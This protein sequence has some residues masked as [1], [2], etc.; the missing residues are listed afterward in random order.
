MAQ[1][2]DKP[3]SRRERQIMDILYETRECSAHDIRAR[4]VDAPS[5]STVR[6]LLAKM[7]EKGY[8]GNR[9]DG[10]RYIYFPLQELGA[11]R[12]N[13]LQRLVKIFFNGSRISAVTALLGMRGGELQEEE[14][15]HLEQLIEK[16]REKQ[17]QE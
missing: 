3:L 7:L 6:A 1:L 5:Y 14:I 12:S 9:Q 2:Q 4:M 15:A 10:A 8:I 16:A 11:V 13:A 17:Q